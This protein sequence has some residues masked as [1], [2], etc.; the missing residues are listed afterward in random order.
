MT[1]SKRGSGASRP[2]KAWTNDVGLTP[3]HHL[4]LFR[5]CIV[6]YMEAQLIAQ[7]NIATQWERY[8]P[9]IQQVSL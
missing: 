8:L 6:K 9:D 1:L 2:K 5:K 3:Y 4:V 7:D